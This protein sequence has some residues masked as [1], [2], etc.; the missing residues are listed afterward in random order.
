[1]RAELKALTGIDARR[2]IHGAQIHGSHAAIRLANCF[3]PQMWSVRVSRY[4]SPMDCFRADDSFMAAIQ[5]PFRIWP[6]RNCGNASWLRR[7][8]KVFSYCLA[9]SKLW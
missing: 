6:E 2:V 9:V 3:H 8:L 1:M 4:K 7:K 5:R